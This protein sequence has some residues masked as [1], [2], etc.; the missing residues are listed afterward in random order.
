M[1]LLT[2]AL[3][4]N[5]FNKIRVRLR[6]KT[7]TKSLFL[8]FVLSAATPVKAMQVNLQDW[9]MPLFTM[10]VFS[11][12]CTYFRKGEISGARMRNVMDQHLQELGS[13]EKKKLAYM[14][15]QSIKKDSGYKD[16]LRYSGL[17]LQA[18]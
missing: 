18:L 5:S 1:A 9:K 14:I 15:E 6:L 13:E 10:G 3:T 16:C 8:I 4:S 12:S 2:R 11:A 7:G 17:D